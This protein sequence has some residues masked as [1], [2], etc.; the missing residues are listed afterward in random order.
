MRP[1]CYPPGRL[2]IDAAPIDPIL[3]GCGIDP[4]SRAGYL[5]SGG[6]GG[7][8][9]GRGAGGSAPTRR[10]TS[11]S[12]PAQDH[13]RQ[14]PG[15]AGPHP[16]RTTPARAHSRSPRLD[17]KVLPAHHCTRALRHCRA[18]RLWVDW[19]AS[20]PASSG[21]P[22][23]ARMQPRREPGGGDSAASLDADALIEKGRGGR[24]ALVG[25]RASDGASARFPI[26]ENHTDE[27]PGWRGETP[28]LRSWGRGFR[29]LV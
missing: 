22:R 25:G 27:G 16:R 2:I 28:R 6:G 17:E 29:A 12:Q 5:M 19:R 21:G 1:R 4:R 10:L 24:A 7:L 3:T 11:L 14:R 8:H 23:R 15:A 20:A 13:R 26:S 18:A 9:T